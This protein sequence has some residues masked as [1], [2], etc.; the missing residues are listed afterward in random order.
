MDFVV[1]TYES[2]I[3][4]RARKRLNYL[5]KIYNLVVDEL[6]RGNQEKETTVLTAK[7]EMR[8]T[9]QLELVRI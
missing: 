4:K 7:V 9:Y 3:L 1:T 5:G 6:P 8:E 2:K